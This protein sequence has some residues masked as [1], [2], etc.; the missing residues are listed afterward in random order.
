MVRQ[1]EAGATGLASM[2][3][4]WSDVWPGSFRSTC[5]VTGPFLFHSH[6]TSGKIETDNGKGDFVNNTPADLAEV[7]PVNQCVR[8]F[9]ILRMIVLGCGL[10]SQLVPI[11]LPYTQTCT[12]NSDTIITLQKILTVQILHQNYKKKNPYNTPPPPPTIQANVLRC[13]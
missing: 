7:F 2:L 10:I 11:S 4:E 1:S 8:W 9:F 12:D 3:C 5:S 13:H 6:Q